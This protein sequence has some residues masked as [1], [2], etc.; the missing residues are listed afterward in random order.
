MQDKKYNTPGS[1]RQAIDDRIESISE[2]KIVD[3]NR[4]RRHLAFDRF[5]ARLFT[6]QEYLWVL[7]GGYA[8]ELRRQNA[9]DTKD[10]DLSIFEKQI[11]QLK[12]S[13]SISNIHNILTTVAAIDLEDFFEFEIGDRTRYLFSPPHGGARFFINSKL[14]GRT[15]AKFHLDVGIGGIK[16]APFEELE[17]RDLLDFAKINCPVFL[18]ISEEQQLAEKLHAYTFLREGK[19]G[20]RV[21]DLVDIVILIQD[22]KLERTKVSKLLKQT[23]EHRHTHQL[24]SKLPS[25]P[26]EWQNLFPKLA[27]GCKIS[28]SLDEAFDKL[29]KFY[30]KVINP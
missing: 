29:Q 17:S 4:L 30:E 12:L 20:S 25:P 21:K 6:T 14:G 1:L 16:I 11:E 3:K 27:S 5:L 9:R 18:A 26:A 19:V 22:G 7:K 23:F 24:P 28:L 13:E 10:I 15:F 8:M 2:A